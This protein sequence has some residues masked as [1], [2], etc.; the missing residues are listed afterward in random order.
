VF[1]SDR[2]PAETQH[3]SPDL[4]MAEHGHL[5]GE[6]CRQ[7]PL[8]S[9]GNSR[10]NAKPQ[11]LKNHESGLKT[12]THKERAVTGLWTGKG[13]SSDMPLAQVS[14]HFC[15]GRKHRK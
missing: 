10:D 4:E 8:V 14:T 1:S 5:H 12:N 11:H 9:W 6:A 13:S 2:S 7:A 3:S 15:M